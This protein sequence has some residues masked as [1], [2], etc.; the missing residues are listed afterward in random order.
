MNLR[1]EKKCSFIKKKRSTNFGS[2]TRGYLKKEKKTGKE[3]I[4]WR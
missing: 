1:F 2:I 4:R 3:E